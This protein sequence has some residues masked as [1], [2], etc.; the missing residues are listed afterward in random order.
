MCL[1]ALAV[2]AAVVATPLPSAAPVLAEPEVLTLPAPPLVQSHAFFDWQNAALFSGVAAGRT[3]DYLSTRRF[4]AKHL[5]E[6][7]LDDEKV[8]N[9]PLFI[10]IEVAGTAVSV[11]ASYL[12]HRTGH[13]RLERWV[14][15]L[16]I[17]FAT[18]GGLWN[19]SLPN[20][21]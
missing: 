6:W 4:R 1:A 18:A 17:A 19:Y 15:I 9:K 21:L 13:H 2:L 11:A 8:D 14:S 7:F 5:K 3:F 10:S 20:G 16:H 12:L